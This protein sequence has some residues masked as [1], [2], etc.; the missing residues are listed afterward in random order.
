MERGQT[1]SGMGPGGK[2]DTCSGMS[3]TQ[4]LVCWEIMGRC[5]FSVKD[6][7]V[8]GPSERAPFLQ[9]RITYSNVV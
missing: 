6:G 8:L 7:N 4:W 5:T 3:A 9:L 2:R 1:E